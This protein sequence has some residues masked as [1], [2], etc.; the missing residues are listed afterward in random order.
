MNEDEKMTA[1]KI[2]ENYFPKT[3]KTFLQGYITHIVG[4]NQKETGEEI[5]RSSKTVSRFK[6]VFGDMNA[7]ETLY[8]VELLARE[9]RKDL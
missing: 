2:L 1:Q 3:G 6:D 9:A 8:V 5:N 4:K 7:E